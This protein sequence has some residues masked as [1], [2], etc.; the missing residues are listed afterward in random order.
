MS[1]WKIFYTKINLWFKR[2]CLLFVFILIN[3]VSTLIFIN[4]PLDA[5]NYF[6]KAFMEK[7]G[8]FLDPTFFDILINI[9]IYLIICFN[10]HFMNLPLNISKKVDTIIN[11]FL[12]WFVVGYHYAGATNWFWA[13]P[14]LRQ[15]M[16]FLIY[17]SIIL[18]VSNIE[19]SKIF[20]FVDKNFA[21][22]ILDY[23]NKKYSVC[24][25]KLHTNH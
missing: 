24:I 11:G 17:I 21:F 13:N 23:S 14:E 10:S 4:S 22:K 2:S 12:G 8:I 1:N 6:V 3:Y 5:G 7:H 16:G 15:T 9:S 18:F 20:W 19:F 25:L